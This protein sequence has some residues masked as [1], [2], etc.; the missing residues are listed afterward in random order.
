MNQSAARTIGPRWMC[1]VIA[2]FPLLLSSSRVEA[3]SI[4]WS[5]PATI[6]SNLNIVNPCSVVQALDFGA[7][8]GPFGNTNVSVGAC[9]VTFVP[10]QGSFPEQHYGGGYLFNE[11]G[12]SV[13]AN[14]DQVLDTVSYSDAGFG[15]T[16]TT[17]FTGLTAGAAYNLQVF[18]SDNGGDVWN[19][20]LDIGGVTTV[21]G[22]DRALSQF[23]TASILLGAGQTSFDLVVSGVS[24]GPGGAST[25]GGPSVNAVVLSQTAVPEPASLLLCA[26]G[27]GLVSV[28]RRAQAR[29]RSRR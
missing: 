2:S 24:S 16:Y 7:A 27:L 28:F 9:T 26:S 20:R 5:A 21:I 4:S 10:A 15:V 3:S 25:R 13:D 22:T 23:A 12:T 18:T 1:A 17:S 19:T 29:T 11:S 14:F 6:T 8:S